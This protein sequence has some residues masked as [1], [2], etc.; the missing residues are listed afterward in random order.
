MQVGIAHLP[1]SLNLLST[2]SSCYRLERLGIAGC[3]RRNVMESVFLD[4]L[5]RVLA[6]WYALIVVGMCCA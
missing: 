2:L 1:V 6:N 3:A 4:G 5:T